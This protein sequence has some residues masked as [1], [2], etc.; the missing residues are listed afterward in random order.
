M[1]LSTLRPKIFGLLILCFICLSS[2]AQYESP[3]SVT[4][5][6]T[7]FSKAF[8]QKKFQ[9]EKYIEFRGSKY[10]ELPS[11]L[12]NFKNLK[13]LDLSDNL[14]TE[15]PEELIKFEKLEQ[16]DLSQNPIKR[17]STR[18]VKIL[19]QLPSLKQLRLSD[20]Q[21]NSVPKSLVNLPGLEILD[22]SQ[23]N[24]VSFPSTKGSSI[25]QLYLEG[26]QLSKI[27]ALSAG[28]HL[29]DVSSNHLRTA[30]FQGLEKLDSLYQI[31]ADN[32]GLK[33][34][35]KN[36]SK[37]KN[38]AVLSLA[39]NHMMGVVIQGGF[40][41]LR[42]LN[43][44]R[45][46]IA[47]ISV[48][49]DS[50][51]YR[52]LRSFNISHNRVKTVPDFL[53]NAVALEELGLGNNQLVDFAFDD[54]E[55][56]RLKSL[57]LQNN[58]ALGYNENIVGL[59]RLQ[60]LDL[61]GL[62]N[63]G[64]HFLDM[65]LEL[66][67]A[68]LWYYDVELGKDQFSK[69]VDPE[70]FDAIVALKEGCD[71]GDLQ[72][73]LNLGVYYLDINFKGIGRLVLKDLTTKSTRLS[74]DDKLEYAD[75]IYT[76]GE[77][78]IAGTIYAQ[79]LNSSYRFSRDELLG[80]GQLLHTRQYR[81]LA[82]SAFSGIIRGLSMSDMEFIKDFG[83]YLEDNKYDSQAMSLYEI[84]CD[85]G[86]R[87]SVEQMHYCTR[88]AEVSPK[89]GGYVNVRN[90]G[91]YSN[92]MSRTNGTRFKMYQRIC[93]TS[94]DNAE[95]NRIREGA[96]KK[97]QTHIADVIKNLESLYE[98]NKKEQARLADGSFALDET[99]TVIQQSTMDNIA[100]GNMGAT[101]AL[102][103]SLASAGT[104]IAAQ[105]K[106]DKFNRLVSQNKNI[107]QDIERLKQQ[108]NSLR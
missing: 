59:K 61:S 33:T 76:K 71:E 101:G 40:Y 21:L 5:K 48:R 2:V 38:L 49:R 1:L 97:C 69:G 29:I 83:D 70:H 102:I 45:N 22:V 96:C 28:L 104:K 84:V 80:F 68:N 15:V 52:E 100:T 75:R 74:Y 85:N 19:S 7:R 43:L 20:A 88:V 72:S 57:Y 6:A 93:N 24:L 51:S 103:G 62:P 41:Q 66:Y 17:L 44:S 65:R 16:L 32:N 50:A 108:A 14:F 31:Y 77:H 47:K 73:C 53:R 55:F 10:S 34:F 81:Q 25:Q 67:S 42:H 86:D 9:K 63:Y 8:R 39:D 64:Q 36:L 106:Q 37:S 78:D 82:S 94:A 18:D 23:N 90:K 105:A 87:G 89:T 91:A 26:N 12:D 92:I 95:A 54:G 13:G 98:F 46:D 4:K 99:G 11:E 107:K 58:S 30:D 56:S 60:N 3:L 27:P 79:A 35:P